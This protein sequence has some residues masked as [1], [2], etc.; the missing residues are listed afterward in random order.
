M[1]WAIA[2]V[3]D[4]RLAAHGCMADLANDLYHYNFILPVNGIVWLTSLAVYCRQALT[5][6]ML[7]RW[8]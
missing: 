4:A 2:C 5:C 8:A 7:S 3:F 1:L 6:R